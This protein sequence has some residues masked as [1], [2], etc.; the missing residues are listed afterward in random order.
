MGNTYPLVLGGPFYADTAY[1]VL[2]SWPIESR[3]YPSAGMV[4]VDNATSSPHM[5]IKS[6][7]VEYADA[8]RTTYTQDVS[9]L[10]GDDIS[11]YCAVT[12]QSSF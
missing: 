1:T 4:Y 11:N 2:P 10:L 9:K 5:I 6:I 8:K 12:Q 7:E 3:Y